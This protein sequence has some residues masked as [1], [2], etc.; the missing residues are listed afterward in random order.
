MDEK[1]KRGTIDLDVDGVGIRVE[2]YGSGLPVVLLHGLGGPLSWGSVP[3]ILA[4]SCRVIVIHF[5]GFGASS[6]N[7]KSFLVADHA[8]TVVRILDLL[9]TD[10]AAIVG[11]SFGTL[12]AVRCCA[13]HPT[14]FTR[15]V[16]I[17]SVG[18]RRG[19]I[20]FLP[21]G[22]TSI[23][24]YVLKFTVLRSEKLMCALSARSFYDVSKRPA[25]L[26]HQFYLQISSP[27]GRDAW[28]MGM[29]EVIRGNPLEWP[30]DA[31]QP[32]LMIWG[33]TD[34]SV[35]NGSQRIISLR[36]PSIRQKIIPESG[37]SVALECPEEV[38][39]LVHAF[40]KRAGG[41]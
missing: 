11:N 36:F 37:H 14:R 2:T 22:I 13:E 39:K 28:V 33:E 12:V 1:V 40:V 24:G 7:G 27:G 19:L 3:E 26:C 31:V 34:R 25:D 10:R 9:G 32:M 38:A 21:W 23:L 8:S 16:L 29:R 5:A 4:Q 20:S 30:G 18:F 35:R 15:A 41:N 6:N 17:N